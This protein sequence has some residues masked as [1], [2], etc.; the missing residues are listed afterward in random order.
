MS[1]DPGLRPL[2]PLAKRLNRNALTVA[3]V[4][5]GITVLTAVVVLT[6]GRERGTIPETGA[7]V[8]GGPSRPTFLEEPAQAPAAA[9]DNT[10]GLPSPGRVR[11]VRHTQ[12]SGVPYAEPPY[13]LTAGSIASSREQAFEA[14]LRSP[15]FAQASQSQHGSPAVQ[16][17]PLVSGED[18]LIAFADSLAAAG[19]H[20]P[21]KTTSAARHREFL[22]NTAATA[23]KSVIAQLEPAGSPYI[24]RAGTVMP[25]VLLTG[26]NSD[27][28]GEIVG[29]VSRNVYDSRSQ[30]L[31]LVPKGSKLIGTYDNQVAAGQ[32][33]LLIAWT[34]LILP[35]GRS[36]VLPGLPL[37]D[38]QG[39]TGAADKVNHHHDRVFGRAILLSAISAGAQLSQP[40]QTGILAVPSAGQ[41]AA[42]AL[43]QE[44]SN[45][46]IETLRR[47]MDVSPTITIRQGQPFL[48]FLNGDLVFEG[49]YQAEP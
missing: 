4:L 41:V 37:K 32:G 7:V 34:R 3:A 15:V 38:R 11:R 40:R 45:V 17:M 12:E 29:Q 22:A 21:E 20:P 13:G 2:P 14:A 35:D 27:L 39:Q 24:L 42:G 9:G 8:P 28:P 25:G 18:H 6:P 48:V 49:P 19:K 36:M 33:R 5:M 16:R 44:L 30:R 43:G 46:A 26:I 1:A 23:E 10:P 47:G 31:L